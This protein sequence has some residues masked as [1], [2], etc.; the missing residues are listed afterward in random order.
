MLQWVCNVIAHRRLTHLCRGVILAHFGKN[1][2]FCFYH[3]LA[4]LRDYSVMKKLWQVT[5][6]VTT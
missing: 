5:T 3:L 4:H 1:T 6:E 2:N